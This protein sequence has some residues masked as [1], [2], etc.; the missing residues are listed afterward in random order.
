MYA[1]SRHKKLEV[2]QDTLNS[3]ETF[4][5]ALELSAEELNKVRFKLAHRDL[6]FS[7][8]LF[9]RDSSK[10]TAILD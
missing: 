2:L 7:N 8:I 5:K 9:D 10:I 6:H 4:L 1:I 3:L